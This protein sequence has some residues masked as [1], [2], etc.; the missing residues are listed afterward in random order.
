MKD[1]I[2][3]REQSLPAAWEPA[4]GCWT[5]SLPWFVENNRRA[6][7]RHRCDANSIPPKVSLTQE[8]QVVDLS[9]TGVRLA[10]PNTR[11]FPDRFI[12]I[13]SKNSIG[14]PASVKWRHGTE[15]GAEFIASSSSASGLMH[16]RA[17]LPGETTRA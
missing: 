2:S 3:A 15:V 5:Q 9:R 13:L 16:V 6:A 11:N 17:N 8:C 14:R 10:V 4:K 1:S 7:R 12:L